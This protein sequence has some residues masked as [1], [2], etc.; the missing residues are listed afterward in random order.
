L[1]F[2]SRISQGAVI[3]D[4]GAN[5]GFY[6]FL[7]AAKA[8]K[9]GTVYA[10]EPLAE[11]LSF[12]WQHIRLNQLCNVAVYPAAVS[13]V[14]G[15]L[16]FSRGGSRYSGHLNDQGEIEVAAVTL[17]QFV[18]EEGNPPP[19]LIKIDVEGDEGRVLRGTRRLLCTTHPVIFLATHGKQVHQECCDL[20][21][22]AGY[23]LEGITG[24]PAD[25]TDELLC[26][27]RA[28]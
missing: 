25:G 19:S 26:V 16:R 23:R 2:A 28:S 13:D 14:A 1:A 20:L 18:F 8:G 10:F 15:K 4:V 21:T 11:N 9:V 27:C 12:L 24:E 5:V 17:D 7:A 3:Y 22:S 6:T